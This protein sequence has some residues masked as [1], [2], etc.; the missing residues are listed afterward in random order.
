MLS[1]ELISDEEGLVE[2]E[3]Q[4]NCPAPE[5]TWLAG[6]TKANR[7]TG[8]HDTRRRQHFFVI[9]EA[10]IQHSSKSTKKEK[11]S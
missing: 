2:G 5:K 10:F 4:I 9:M 3:S 6:A 7:Y 1:H 11:K 8:N